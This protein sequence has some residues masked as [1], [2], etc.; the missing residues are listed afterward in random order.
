MT[1][2]SASRRSAA[3]RSSRL[4][5][6]VSEDLSVPNAGVSERLAPLVVEHLVDTVRAAPAAGVSWE[7]IGRALGMSRQAAWDRFAR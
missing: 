7:T 3:R 6:L 5:G 4:G 1:I 2:R